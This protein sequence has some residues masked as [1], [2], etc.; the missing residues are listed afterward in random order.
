MAKQPKGFYRRSDF[1][2]AE[3][4]KGFYRRSD[5]LFA[6]AKRFF[7]AFAITVFYRLCDNGFL[8]TLR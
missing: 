2:F 7:I 3:A 6:E 4:K 1:L 5:F 8:S